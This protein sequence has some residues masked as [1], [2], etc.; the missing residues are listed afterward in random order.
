MSSKPGDT[1]PATVEGQAFTGFVVAIDGPAGAGKSTTARQ[2]AARLSFS[3]LDTGALYRAVA[4][5]ARQ[6]G[7]D[8]SDAPGL[9]AL[10]AAL[11]LRFEGSGASSRV[12]VGHQDVTSGIRA[13]EISEGASRVSAFPEVRG[14]LLELQRA[15]GARGRIVAEGRD[16]GTVVFPSAPAKFFLTAPVQVRAD[17]R[18]RELRAAGRTVDPAEVLRE[19]ELRDQRDRTR[20]VSPLRKAEDAV[21]IDTT[22]RSAEEVVDLMEA[23]VRTRGG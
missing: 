9:A 2:L 18:T 22:A 6:R 10:A 11:D 1:P 16:T 3:F 14:A 8:W 23:V 5:C 13:P 15:I 21:E 17:R 20:A 19:M 7:I 4:L 12:I